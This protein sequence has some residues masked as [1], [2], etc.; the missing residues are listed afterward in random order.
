MPTDSTLPTPH[1]NGY[2]YGTNVETVDTN[3]LSPQKQ[4]AAKAGTLTPIDMTE[5]NPSWAWS[6]GAGISTADDLVKYVQALVGGGLLDSNMQKARLA[7]VV[8]SDPTNPQAAAYGLALARFGALYGHT[9][10]LPGYNTFA[11]YDPQRKLTVV[12]WAATAPSP[13]GRAPAVTM[14]QTIIGE[15]YH[16]G[17]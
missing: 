17:K 7:S 4:A 12:V 10:E 16:T 1:A 9:G 15:L 8:S 14:A 13:D 6:A 2:S 3:V 5:A 11:G